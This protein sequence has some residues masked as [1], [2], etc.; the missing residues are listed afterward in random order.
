MEKMLEIEN[1]M[2]A[3]G[4][5]GTPFVF[6]IDYKGTHSHIFNINE[7]DDILWQTPGVS[8]YE[9]RPINQLIEKWAI[10]PISFNDYKQKF[11]RVK[12]FIDKGDTYLINFTQPTPVETN[13]VLEDIFYS[14][15]APYKIYLKNKFVCFSPESFVKIKD[16]KIFSFPMKGT[17]DADADNAEELILKDI[18]EIAEHN[19]IVDLI[20]NDLSQVAENVRVEKFR[21]LSHIKTNQKNLWQVSTEISGV[22]PLNYKENIGEIINSLLPAGSISGA[23]KKKTLEIIEDTEN[24]DRG[25]Y[26]GIFGVFDG[27]NIDSCVLI[28]FIENKNGKLIYKSGGGITFLSDVE[29]EYHEMLEKVYVPII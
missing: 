16:G 15:S 7:S 28:R 27:E 24:Y 23:P 25:Y 19:T 2:N 26:T 1:Q 9:K 10:D 6:L 22:L 17:I 21:Y 18:K 14:A 13:L 20:R 11:D 12:Q 3:L 8:N 29:K 5:A 4:K